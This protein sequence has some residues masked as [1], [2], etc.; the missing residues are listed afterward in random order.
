MSQQQQKS[1][2]GSN[3]VPDGNNDGMI[4]VPPPAYDN[5]AANTSKYAPPSGAPD[6]FYQAQ[7]VGSSSQ[8]QTYAPPTIAG[9]GYEP[10][11]SPMGGYPPPSGPPGGYAPPP[12]PPGGYGQA[13]GGYAPPSGQPGKLSS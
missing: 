3:R 2:D 10:P 4:Q 7:P 1:M 13:Y 6:N 5:S 9:G 12:G 8:Q 11:M